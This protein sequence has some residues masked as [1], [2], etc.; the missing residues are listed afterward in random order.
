M[1]YRDINLLPIAYKVLA[2]VLCEQLKP[3]LATPPLT[4]SSNYAK[5]WKGPMKNKPHKG[6][7]FCDDVRI[8]LNSEL[9]E[10]FND[11]DVVQRI[12]IQRL[13]CLGH[14][15]HMEKDETGF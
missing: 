13:R 2:G 14:I 11:M 9:Y 10:L 12:N 6:L 4:R 3:G 5:S 8:R 7:C 15:V 1:C